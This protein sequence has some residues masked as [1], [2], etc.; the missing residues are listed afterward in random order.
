MQLSTEGSPLRKT[1]PDPPTQRPCQ[2]CLFAIRFVIPLPGLVR[3]RAAS[4]KT[5]AYYN[6]QQQIMGAFLL[7][8]LCH[9]QSGAQAEQAGAEAFVQCACPSRPVPSRRRE[10]RM[11]WVRP[12]PR[13]PLPAT[14]KVY[15]T[16][17]SHSG[18]PWK[19][20]HHY[21]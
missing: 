13:G 10:S 12:A 18:G 6:S 19:P 15:S 21:Q 11:G 16:D 3:D 7:N 9:V 8:D 2:A 5:V 4:P 1:D 17:R 14:A 20:A